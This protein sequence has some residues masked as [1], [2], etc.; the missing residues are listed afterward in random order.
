MVVQSCLRRSM[1]VAIFVCSAV[2]TFAQLPT[3]TILGIV[4]DSTGAVLPGSSVTL[5]NANTGVTRAAVTDETG[6]YRVPAL[7]VGRYDIVVELP[8]FNTAVQRGVEL[9]V[10]QEAVVN[11]TLQVGAPT[12]QVEVTAEAVQV[13]TTTSSQTKP[14]F[15]SC[16]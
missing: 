11:F 14:G 15:P 8:G 13:D 2:L 3:G 6:V 12:Q 16:R 5:R 7:P 9:T 1:A 10:T 4:K